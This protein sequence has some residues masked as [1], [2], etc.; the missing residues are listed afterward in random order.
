MNVFEQNRATLRQG[1][2]FPIILTGFDK[3]QRVNDSAYEFTQEANF[4]YLTGIE[5]AGWRLIIDSNKS[6]LVAPNIDEIHHIF[7]GGL[8]RDEAQRISGIDEIVST[9]KGEALLKQLSETYDTAMTLGED[10]HSAHYDF[11]LNPAAP[12]L[13]KKLKKLFKNVEDIRVPLAKL[14][15]IKQPSEQAL[16]Q[17]AIDISIQAFESLHDTLQL[18]QQEYQ[19]EAD[20]SHSFR[21]AG[22]SGHAYDPIVASGKN[23]CTLHYGKNMDALPENGL[24]LIDAGARYGNYAADITRTYAI[25]TPTDRQ[26]SVHAAVEKAH[27]KIIALIAPGLSIKTYSEQVDEIM[28]DALKSVDLLK[29]KDDYRR[30]FPHAISHGLGIDVHDSLGRTKELQAGMIL[31]VEPGIYIPEEGI[32]VRIEDDILVTD[33][34]HVNLSGK[35]STAL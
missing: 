21:Y 20:L 19:L 22:A 25:G 11:T 17:Q 12:L 13:L 23:A 2:D 31:T 24:V 9:E 8:S 32:G 34:G 16:I 35:L 18:K 1:S 27:H 4:W 33:E 30:Y 14:R 6:T 28:K 7:E 5:E 26:K 29:T 3:L 15:A 10:P